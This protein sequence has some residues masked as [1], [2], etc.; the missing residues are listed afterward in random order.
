MKEKRNK[1]ADK[2]KS[3]KGKLRKI[4]YTILF[5]ITSG[6]FCGSL[7]AHSD[8][9]P[10]NC[11]GAGID[12]FNVMYAANSSFTCGVLG[13]H[14]QYTVNAG[15]GKFKLYVVDKCEPG[16][17]VDILITFEKTDTE[18]HGFQITAQD[19][20]YGSRVVG[21]F[22]NVGDDDDTQ[23]EAGGRFATHT[24]KGTQQKFWHVKWQAPPASFL[25]ANHVKLY[26]MGIEAN[27][28]GTSMGDY[29]YKATRLITVEKKK[30][31]KPQVRTIKKE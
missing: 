2:K 7:H 11:V 14:Y 9:A 22:I 10:L 12:K 15:K 30:V 26:A 24:K 3:G 5:M 27:N 29:I 28:D 19:S 8:G 4:L 17:I 16:D 18:F 25:V 23:V 20:Y 13:C 31:P 21:T 1:D 6:V